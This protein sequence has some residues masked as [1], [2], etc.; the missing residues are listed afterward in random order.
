M[1]KMWIKGVGVSSL[2]STASPSI[3]KLAAVL[4]VCTAVIAAIADHGADHGGVIGHGGGA[5]GFGGHGGGDIGHG[6]H[7]GG[8]IG[9]GEHG[10]GG[11]GGYGG[12]YNYPHS[13]PHYSYKVPRQ[14]YKNIFF[15]QY[16]SQEA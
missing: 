10:G 16:N 14:E 9:H 4:V 11:Y 1:S 13:P 15:S 7:L 6:G 12:G 2:I 8:G 3:M 5:L